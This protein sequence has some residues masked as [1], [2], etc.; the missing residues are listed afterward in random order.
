MEKVR[1][2]KIFRFEMAHALMGYDG[3][4]SNL[5]GHSYELRVTVIGEPESAA[6]SPK[7]GMLMDF[8]D[9]KRIV[10]A[11]I[12]DRFDHALVL[13]SQSDR[14]L[15]AQL[16]RHYR[17]VELVPY[18]PTSE[19]MLLHFAE[20]LRQELPPQ[21]RLHSLRLGETATSYAEWHAE[22]NA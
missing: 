18:Q 20:M 12:V 3:L 17:K 21:V 1:I 14:E 4:C 15:V 19:R 7:C 8:S 10:N 6:A 2:T 16:C 13:N 9:L 11:C 5:H 22:D